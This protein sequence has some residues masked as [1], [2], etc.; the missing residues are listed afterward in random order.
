MS[1][2]PTSPGRSSTHYA[3]DRSA[4]AFSFTAGGSVSAPGTHPSQ[5]PRS[6]MDGPVA[7]P[8]GYQSQHQQQQYGQYRPQYPEQQR[9]EIQPRP[10]GTHPA[11]APHYQTSYSQT[12]QLPGPLPLVPTARS[13]V[14]GMATFQGPTSL[15]GPANPRIARTSRR[16]KAHV[17]RAC[18]NCKKAH[19]SCDEARPCARCVSSGKQATCIDVEH[20]KRGRPR[21]RDDR[22]QR[23]EQAAA[24]AVAAAVVTARN[25]QRPSD[26]SQRGGVHGHG[27]GDSLRV[28]RSQ[29]SGSE[30]L[31]VE[32]Q[33]QMPHPMADPRYQ[34]HY[35]AGPESHKV[36]GAPLTAF[37]NMDLRILKASNEIRRLFADGGDIR[38]RPLSDFI[39]LQ[40]QQALQRIQSDLRDERSSREPSFLPGIF[41]EQQEQESVA[42]M[43]VEAAESVSQGYSERRETFSFRM[44]SG[45]TEQLHLRLRLAKTRT[46]FATLILQRQPMQPHSMPQLSPYGRPGGY[47]PMPQP[48]PTQM[49]FPQHGPPSPYN[50]NNS[51]PSSPFSTL[52]TALITTLPPSSSHSTSYSYA[53]SQARADP[54]FLSVR[55]PTSAVAGMYPPPPPSSSRPPSA[56]PESRPNTARERHRPAPLGSLQLP[57]IVNSAPTTPM[58]SD[59]FHQQQIGS[60]S[61]PRPQFSLRP[62]PEN[63][64]SSDDDEEDQRKRR[65]LDIKQIIER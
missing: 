41:P 9:Y 35:Q 54:G 17:A 49:A 62:S 50:A 19:L 58:T 22:D 15:G 4:G 23:L 32:A 39:G 20:K 10:V 21:L 30:G 2:S 28:L 14:P 61:E 16:A 18:Q 7:V 59:F 60:S 64:P 8:A 56:F 38:G 29:A 1:G 44:A 53:P 46:F 3:D 48:S 47:L 52:H 57:P 33:G 24:A 31:Q 26:L 40:H 6:S 45:R 34:Q 5:P 37:L 43:D 55:H 11:L 42:G 63:R 36:G 51:A 27:R 25:A 65:R 12:Q 13:Q